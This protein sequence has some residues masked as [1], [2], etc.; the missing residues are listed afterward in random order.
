MSKPRRAPKRVRRTADEARTAILDATE[1]ML[2]ETGPA[3]IRLQQVAAEVGVSHPTVLHHFGSREGLVQAVV[4]R[5]LAAI[6]SDVIE[7]IAR[8]PR[9]DE[10]AT[11]AMLERVGEA[12]VREGHGRALAWCA[13]AGM[14]SP[15]EDLGL[16]E[17]AKAVHGIR[18][19]RRG[20]KAL[21]PKF[22]DTLFTVSLAMSVLFAQSVAGPMLPNGGDRGAAARYSRWFARLI[23]KHLREGGDVEPPPRG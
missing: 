12:L 10:D 4:G 15:I 23:L 21:T 19:V 9:D 1:R 14:A 2:V 18:E 16:S 3:A 7:A 22:E 6:R 17:I 20:G 13:L 8:F 5:A 11:T